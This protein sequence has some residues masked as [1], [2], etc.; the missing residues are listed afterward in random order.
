MPQLMQRM[1]SYGR[2][3]W[4]SISLIYLLKEEAK[5]NMPQGQFKTGL[6]TT[7]AKEF[8]LRT[9]KNYNKAQLMQKYQ[10]LKGRHHT[11]S[12]LIG[13]IGMGWDPIANTM[14]GSEAVLASAIAHFFMLMLLEM[15]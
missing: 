15:E 9:N 6:W 7:I 4:R 13:R 8:Y 11:F 1:G 14:M 3:Q 10:R 5:G 12:Q 2:R